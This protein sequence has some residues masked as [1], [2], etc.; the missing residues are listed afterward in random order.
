[1]NGNKQNNKRSIPDGVWTKCDKC[2]AIIFDKEFCQSFKVCPKCD[3]HH[4]LNFDERIKQLFDTN[5]FKETLSDLVT[6]DPL[7]FKAEE[8]Y[9]DYYVKKRSDTGLKEAII[10]GTAKIN[11]LQANIAV[12]DFRFI[13]GSM[14]TIVGEKVSLTIEKSL[15]NIKP[16]IIITASGG[17]RMQEG[18]LSLMQMAKT[19]AAIGKLADNKIP[20][21]TLLSNPTTGG[22]LASF[23]TQ[24]DLIIA[25]PGAHIGFAGPRVIEKTI[26]QRLP[27]GFQ[28][29]EFLLKHGMIDKIVRRVDQKETIWRLLTFL[30]EL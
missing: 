28:T 3:F 25:E 21:I 19:S 30:G 23:A 24:A 22:V 29:A 18:M 4:R 2:K 26:K 8:S 17:A 15:K 9:R 13:G 12:M 1:M 27:E 10:T 11:G 5:S 6:K 14:G 7:N 20:F 16:L